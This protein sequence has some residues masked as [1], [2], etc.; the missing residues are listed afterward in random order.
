MSKHLTKTDLDELTGSPLKSRQIVFLNEN[1]IPYFERLDGHPF[2]LWDSVT[3][4]LTTKPN[5]SVRDRGIN[6]Q[7]AAHG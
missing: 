2:V 7:A 4:R 6:M 5:E 1:R 3:Q